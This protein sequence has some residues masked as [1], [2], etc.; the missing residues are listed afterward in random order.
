[1]IIAMAAPTRY[2]YRTAASR[3][4][5]LFMH[6]TVDEVLDVSH[7]FQLHRN[8]PERFR[9]EPYIVTGAGHDD[10][11]EHDPQ[12]YFTTL[13]DFLVA[14]GGYDAGGSASSATA[15]T[16]AA[17]SGEIALVPSSR[18]AL[19]R[20]THHAQPAHLPTSCLLPFSTPASSVR[21]S[22]TSN[23]ICALAASGFASSGT[24]AMTEDAS[25][26]LQPVGPVGRAF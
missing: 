11:A 14:V 9:R 1:M 7:T 19:P 18:R 26:L 22:E 23:Q 13:Q 6:G 3:S 5:T 8:C 21:W 20:R 2:A 16:P 25:D 24:I 12:G 15:S 4:P 17:A 10:I